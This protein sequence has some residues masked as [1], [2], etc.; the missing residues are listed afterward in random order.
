MTTDE[1][2]VTPQVK[3]HF[4]LPGHHSTVY[5]V[6]LP[7]ILPQNV[8]DKMISRYRGYLCN[9]L[10]QLVQ[11]AKIHPSACLL[12]WTQEWEERAVFGDDS[13][14]E[15]DYDSMSNSSDHW[16]LSDLCLVITARPN[17]TYCFL[18]VKAIGLEPHQ[19]TQL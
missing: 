13:E 14:S 9:Q 17:V 12:G 15:T 5:D 10:R 7:P 4:F 1:E 2:D 16:R 11:P 8:R 18:A 19:D 6:V 3:P